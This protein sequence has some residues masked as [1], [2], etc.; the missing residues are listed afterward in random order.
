M[1]DPDKLARQLAGWATLPD[2]QE[3]RQAHM[4]EAAE[5]ARQKEAVEL[6]RRQ[7]KRQVQIAANQRLIASLEAML[8]PQPDP[9]SENDQAEH[10][11][12]FHWW[13]R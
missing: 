9:P 2:V 4:R 13:P 5:Q 10:P 6:Q 1:H 3:R 11:L 8:N 7:W 12:K